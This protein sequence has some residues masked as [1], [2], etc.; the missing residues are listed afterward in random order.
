MLHLF[1][2]ERPGQRRGIPIL[3]P[4]IEELKQITRL[5]KA[6]LDAAVL[7]AYFTVF[8]KSATTVGPGLAEGFVPPTVGMPAGQPG[9]S[10]K[11]A[12][13]PRD[14]AIYEMGSAN[15]VEMMEGEEIQMADPKRPNQH[16]EPF[17][18]AMV[19]QIGASIEVPFEQLLLHFQSSYSAARGA[20]QEAWKTYR[21]H[22]TFMTRYFCQ[23]VYE[24]WLTE[25]ILK[26]RISAPGFFADPL[27]RK[28]WS[29][30]AWT[31]PGQGQLDP[32]K[33]TT[34]AALRIDKRL[35][36]HEDEFVAISGGD[37]TGAMNRL[38]REETHLESLDLQVQPSSPAPANANEN[39]DALD[40]NEQNETRRNQGTP[41]TEEDEEA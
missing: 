17:Y 38:S 33:E 21:S 36:T 23:P 40:N 12:E 6:E 16:F 14:D 39:P 32:L 41:P 9:V 27:I 4:V 3:A 13:D 1:A 2:K 25:A 18:M 28:A 37:W 11:N 34:A 22:R 10:D 35:S 8:V 31:G 15:I 26:G 20:L 7:N 24:E 30:A 5:S 19:K 29:A